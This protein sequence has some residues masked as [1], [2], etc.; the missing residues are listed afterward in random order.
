MSTNND[1]MMV[2][3]TNAYV[4][5]NTRD[6]LG[7]IRTLWRNFSGLP[8]SFNPRGGNRYFTIDL[9]KSG[10]IEVGNDNPMVGWRPVTVNELIEMGWKVS[11]YDKHL[12]KYPDSIPNANLNVV[13][14][15][16]DNPADKYRDPKIFQ[17]YAGRDMKMVDHPR[18]G[19]EDEIDVGLLDDLWIDRAQVRLGHSKN[20]VAYLDVAHIY[21]KENVR[22]Y[23]D[24]A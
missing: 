11:I 9:N 14:S 18:M 22:N 6:D 8:T 4:R 3:I 21:P 24:W 10:L 17:H 5:P 13:V 19:A 15:F 20:M 1:Y 16:H 12:E 7:N 2:R 23:D